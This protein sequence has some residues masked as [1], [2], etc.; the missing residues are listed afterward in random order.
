V[1][2]R[3][4]GWSYNPA[5]IVPGF[6][7][8]IAMAR[9]PRLVVPA[10]PHHLVQRACDGARAF[11]DDQDCESFLKWLR[12]AARLYRVAIHA[13]VL[14]PDQ[15]QL[16]ATPQ[17]EQ[18]LARMMQ[19]VGRQYVPYFNSRHRRRGALWQGRFRGAVVEADDYLLACSRFIELAPV[20]G[21]LCS[22]PA[23]YRWSSY[24]HHA[25]MQ[26]DPVV[27]DHALHWTLGNTPF[28]REAAYRAYVLDGIG[29]GLVERLG[30]EVEKGW[31]LGSP[32][33]KEELA[34]QLGRRVTPGERGRPA[35]SRT[36]LVRHAGTRP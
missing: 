27:T 12:E 5:I 18:G 26:P 29:S 22:D 17:D 30:Q 8:A 6:A 13:Y 24:R 11:L 4:P 1:A 10:H 7:S 36:K 32:G 23:A 33:F 15:V 20:H 28:D 21:G 9:L 3:S 31:P 35:A 34:R 25:G 19:W 16:L 2:R 14:L